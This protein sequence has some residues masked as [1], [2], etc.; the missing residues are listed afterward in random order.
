MQRV[1]AFNRFYLPGYQA[2]GP[3]VSLANMISTLGDEI[4]FRVITSDRDIN[5]AARYPQIAP[6]LWMQQ[7]NA[8]VHYL[9]KAETTIKRV[10]TLVKDIAPDVIYLNSFFDTWFS[11]RV[12]AAHRLGKLPPCRLVL[13]PRGEFSAGAL[14]IKPFRK[15][16]YMAALRELRLLAPVEWHASTDME[17]AELRLALRLQPNVKIHVAADLGSLPASDIADRWQPRA[18]DAPLRLCFLSRISP[19][20]NLLGAISMLSHMRAPAQ[21]HIFGPKEDQDYW[22]EC[23]RAAA[24]LPAH[25]TA[26]YKGPVTPPSIHATLAEYDA[27]LF[28]T[29][30][31]NYGHVIPEALS[32]GLPVLTSDRTPWRGLTAKGIGYDG[33]LDDIA[34]ASQLDHL[35]GLS[36][37]QMQAIRN[38][39]RHFARGVLADPNKIQAN[40]RLFVG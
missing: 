17:A 38:S 4:S 40:R 21:L 9:G 32:V 2:G 34:F 6:D 19:K 20:K 14:A 30:G 13:A 1:L 37:E 26:I 23:E 33:P 36:A 29:F 8:S 39:A 7:G 28:P 12:L 22:M 18:P 10:A 25:I 3:I 5:D 15:R 16:A 27:M 31:E 24:Q 35:A 11:F